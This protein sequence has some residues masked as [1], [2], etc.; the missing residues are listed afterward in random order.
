MSI[1]AA[2]Y[3]R[4]REQ[5]VEEGRAFTLLDDGNYLVFPVSGQ[6]VIPFWSS[7][8]RVEKVQQMHANLR[9]FAITQLSLAEFLELLPKLEADRVRV[10][11]NWSGKRLTGY[12]VEV[13]DVQAGLQYWLDKRQSTPPS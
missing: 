10:G 12:D 3:A 8:S 4:F 7:R 6:E 13:R 5:V 1:A 2:A 11:A 9:A